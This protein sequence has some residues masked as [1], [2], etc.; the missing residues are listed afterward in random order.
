M[1]QMWWGTL[2]ST[3]HLDHHPPLEEGRYLYLHRVS[4]PLD[5][6]MI[7]VWVDM[8]LSGNGQVTKGNYYISGNDIKLSFSLIRWAKVSETTRVCRIMENWNFAQEKVFNIHI[9]LAVSNKHFFFSP[10]SLS[11]CQLFSNSNVGSMTIKCSVF[12]IFN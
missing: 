10:V 7:L 12:I 2:V 6:H 4:P 3:Y 9:L 11:Q 1:N 5:T 8:G